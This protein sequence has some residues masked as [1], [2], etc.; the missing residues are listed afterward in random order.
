[1]WHMS[2]EM[3]PNNEKAAHGSKQLFSDFDLLIQHRIRLFLRNTNNSA[4]AN[5]ASS[6][7]ESKCHR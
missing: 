6:S 1:M 5:Q 2:A 7:H 3:L 4:Q